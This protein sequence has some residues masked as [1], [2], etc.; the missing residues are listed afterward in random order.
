V[1]RGL[2]ID[3]FPGHPVHLDPAGGMCADHRLLSADRRFCGVIDHHEMIADLV[4]G[5]LVAARQQRRGVGNRGAIPVE[6]AITQFLGA[7]DVALCLRQPHF[8]R[9]QSPQR[10]RKIGET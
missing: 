6:Y 3:R 9:A 5:I 8:E 10:G 4:E 7:L 2:R 1:K